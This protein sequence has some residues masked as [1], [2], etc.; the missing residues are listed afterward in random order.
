[1]GLS[2]PSPLRAGAG[3]LPAWGLLGAFTLAGAWA[4]ARSLGSARTLATVR[5][6][7]PDLAAVAVLYALFTAG[8]GVRFRLLLPGRLSWAEAVGLGWL[9][10]AVVSVLPGGL[11]ELAVPV[12]CRR[13]PGGAAAAT[14][15]VVLSR[16][17][18][19]LSWVVVVA[20]VAPLLTG[21]VVPARL[22]LAAGTA[23]V[24]AASA[25]LLWPRSRRALVVLGR[26]LPLAGVQAFLDRLDGD[27]GAMA[28]N[29]AA[30]V[31]TFA[32]RG[33]SVGTY[34]FALHAF[35]ARVTVAEAA[36]GGALVALLLV[37]PVQG[38]AGL[39]TVE[40]W[41]ITALRLF[42]L[43]WP[44]AAVAAIGLHLALLLGSLLVGLA[45]VGL[46]PALLRP[47]W[48]EA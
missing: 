24:C 41:W 43:S 26:A 5:P 23:A 4:V 8:R 46:A 32:L 44:V 29:G 40:V 10:S 35:G 15:A 38:I 20:G 19:L 37:L 36:A 11:G 21:L 27:L 1:M 34:Y 17:Q 14:A 25:A 6:Q 33:L 39:G 16:I 47:G 45:S 3:R 31:V 30:W 2:G 7:W 22:G 28:R 12:L 42:G 48:Q 18:D 13:A 9:Y